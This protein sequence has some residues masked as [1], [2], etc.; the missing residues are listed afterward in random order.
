MRTRN[1]D[2]IDFSATVKTPEGPVYKVHYGIDVYVPPDPAAR[3]A[4]LPGRWLHACEDGKP[5]LYESR[6]ERD[7]KRA[8]LRKLPE[9]R[10]DPKGAIHGR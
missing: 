5:L 7:A 2:W 1:N 9:P 8:E 3:A 6:E 4:R 10:R